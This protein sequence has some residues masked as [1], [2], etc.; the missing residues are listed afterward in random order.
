MAKQMRIEVQVL[1]W[2][3]KLFCGK[4]F[5]GASFFAGEIFLCFSITYSIMAERLYAASSACCIV[6]QRT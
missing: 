2:N 5:F 1:W 4:F 6:I 3:L